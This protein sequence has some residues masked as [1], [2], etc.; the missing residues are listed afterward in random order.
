M[1][2]LSVRN[3]DDDLV[4][5]L[6]RRAARHGQ[7]AEAEVREIL[8][9]SLTAESE[10]PSFEQLAAELRSLTLGRQ[11]T[12]AEQLLREGRDER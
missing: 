11:H 1:A 10:E 9:Q 3:L 12:P 7:S 8:R 5:R 6:K 2:S 4:A